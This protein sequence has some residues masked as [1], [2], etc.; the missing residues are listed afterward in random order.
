MD[1]LPATTLAAHCYDT[2][3]INN[4][5]IT[6]APILP[7]ETLV[8]NCYRYML[9][10]CS[11]LSKVI[12]KF[13]TTPSSSYTYNWLSDSTSNFYKNPNATWDQTISRSNSTVPDKW[14]IT[15]IPSTVNYLKFTTVDDNGSTYAFSN[16]GLEYSIDGGEWTTLAANT[17]TPNVP[18]NSNIRFRGY[19]TPN[20]EGTGR[21]SSS[22]KFNAE[23]ELMTLL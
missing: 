15:D 11:A 10:G 5:R 17:N 3:F 16:P 4:A 7:A 18:K 8:D 1:I 9:W 2:M 14:T 20:G 6:E 22:G 13:T 19:L 23:G 21:F 12:A